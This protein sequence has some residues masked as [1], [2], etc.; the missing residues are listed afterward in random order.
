MTTLYPDVRS[1]DASAGVYAPQHD[2]HLLIE[3]LQ[4]AGGVAGRSVAD[5]CTGSGVVAIAA[6]QLGARQVTAFD[7]SGQAVECARR[8]S[9]AAGVRVDVRRGT[10]SDAA[11]LGPY[12]VLLSNPPYVPANPRA[13]RHGVAAD[14]GP[15]RAWDAGPDGRLVLDPLCEAAPAMLRDGA[16][17]LIVQS[18]FADPRRTVHS[19]RRGG[20]DAHVFL[21]RVIPFGPVLTARAAWMERTGL[22]E[23]GRREE[24]IVVVRAEKR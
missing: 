22:L 24:E 6:A 4:D 12:D 23:P 9:A 11:R 10:C 19:L 8:N 7:I 21:S 5:I 1:V 14:V 17:L 15:S 2:S 20:L 3:A 16:T 13:G 18:E